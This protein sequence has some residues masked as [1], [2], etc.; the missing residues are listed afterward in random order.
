M[1][2]EECNKMWAPYLEHF[3]VAF[4]ARNEIGALRLRARVWGLKNERINRQFNLKGQWRSEFDKEVDTVNP[5]V[6]RQAALPDMQKRCFESTTH[7]RTDCDE[8]DARRIN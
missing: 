2:V 7:A 3:E 6:K 8:V 5:I 4:S 1:Q